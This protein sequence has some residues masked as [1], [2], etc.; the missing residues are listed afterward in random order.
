MA[1]VLSQKQIDELLGNLNSGEIDIKEI[2][3]K[4]TKKIK[5]Y[6]FR[7][8]KKFTREQLKFIDNIFDNFTRFFEL[9]LGSMLRV[10]CQMSIVQTEEEEYRDFNNALNDSVLAGVMSI[11]SNTVKLNFKQFIIEIARP[12]S[13]SIIDRLLGG[14]GS[15]YNIERDYTDIELS[16]MRHLFA[17]ICGQ[18]NN[19]WSNY[20]DFSHQLDLIETNSRL[21]Q[22]IPPDETTV[23]LVIETKIE[24]LV[25]NINICLPARILE[26]LFKIFDMKYPKE[27]NK[28]DF[29]HDELRKETIMKTLKNAPLN[30]TGVLGESDI[31]LEELLNIQVGDVLLLDSKVKDNSVIIKIQDSP[32]F[33][34]TMGINK[35]NYAV[36]IEQSVEG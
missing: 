20:G 21:I 27:R 13:F 31:T 5:D 17:Q 19:A 22:F 18:L 11:D 14:D 7:S 9:Q 12:L 8:P 33:T 34:G 28:Q 16:L 29:E 6:D 36:K 32:W 26:G 30:V 2:E 4:S 35:K 25:G 24:N 1:E 15:C 23:I 10:G 3:E